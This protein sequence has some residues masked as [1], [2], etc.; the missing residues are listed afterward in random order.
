[1]SDADQPEVRRP[2]SVP[3]D[4]T[5]FVLLSVFTLIET[6]WPQIWA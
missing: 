2:L 5:K 1:M 3:L 6:N 4:D